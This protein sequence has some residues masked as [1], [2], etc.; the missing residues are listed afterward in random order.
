MSS[1]LDCGLVIAIDVGDLGSYVALEPTLSMAARSVV[2]VTW[3]PLFGGLARLS[4][5]QP[6][7]QQV[8]PLAAYKARRQVA[9]DKWAQRELERNCARL[10]IDVSRGGRRFDSSLAGIGLLFVRD[11]GEDVVEYLRRVFK[12]AWDEAGAVE[13]VAVLGELFQAK[14]FAEFAAGEGLQ[15]FEAIQQEL[16]EAGV[17]SS[18]AYVVNGEVFQGRQHLPLVGQISS[19]PASQ[20]Q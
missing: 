15:Q 13:D 7:A 17:F 16:L 2:D 8:D 5:R 11:Q 9:R 12:L 1:L 19:G 18:P 6:Q 3:L 20:G 4:A 10:G 14:G